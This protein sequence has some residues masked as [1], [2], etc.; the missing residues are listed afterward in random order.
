[1][2]VVVPCKTSTNIWCDV[3]FPPDR[4]KKAIFNSPRKR[5]RASEGRRRERALADEERGRAYDASDGREGEA[6]ANGIRGRE[7]GRGEEESRGRWGMGFRLTRGIIGKH[8]ISGNMT[9][10]HRYFLPRLT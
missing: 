7:G 6:T 8:G 5:R 1:M 4:K 9:Y 2:H 3:L 10:R